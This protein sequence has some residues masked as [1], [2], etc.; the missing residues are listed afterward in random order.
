VRAGLFFLTLCISQLSF[1][2]KRD[3]VLREVTVYGL[4]EEKY[5]AGSILQPLDSSLKAN[6]RSNNLGEILSYQLPVYFRTYGNGMS[7]GISM[8]GTSPQHTSVLWNGINVNSFS[9]G[10]ADF[11]ILPA[12]AFDEVKVH[13][14]AGSA[15]YGSGA[16]GGSILMNSFSSSKKNAI[17]IAQDAG[18]FGRY[19]SSISG[20]YSTGRW[21]FKTNLYS[22]SS[23]NN[24]LILGTGEHQQHASF[25]QSGALQDIEYKFT[26]GKSL[27][28]HYWY[29]NADRQIQPAIG[30]YNSSDTQQDRNH[31]LSIHYQSHSQ[32]GLLSL[33]GGYIDDVIVFNGSGSDVTR[34]ISKAKHEFVFAQTFHAQVSA[35]W[36]HIIGHIPNYQDGRAQEDRY[37]FTSS[38][39]K[40]IGQR[41]SF[42]INLRQPVVPGFAAPFLPYIGIEFLPMKK[43]GNELKVY[44]SVS[45]NYRV[46]TLNDRYW[47]NAGDRN[48]LPETSHA[49]EAGWSWRYKKLEIFNAW[50]AQRVDDWIQWTPDATGNYRPKNIEQVLARGIELKINARPKIKNIVIV[51]MLSYQLTQSI[52]TKAPANQQYTIGNQLIFTPRHTASAFVQVLWNSYSFDVSAQYNGMRFTDAGNTP[53]YA[54]PAYALLNF[55]AGRNWVVHQHRFDVRFAVKNILNTDYQLY[56]AHAMPGR[57]YNLQINYQFNFKTN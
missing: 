50:F 41:L 10:Q 23:E 44:G 32:F 39:Q 33:N 38:L 21:R 46:P 26:E 40:N 11:S 37:D 27:G 2:Q 3:S 16:F 31:R 4:P 29:H 36:N 15:R 14:G 45:K 57:N 43:N 19:F 47:Q 20:S 51:P 30:Q 12:A 42:A 25:R 52:T 24:F 35:E 28:I 6:N 8:R 13:E 55:S 54:L 48:L 9:L 34:W 5:L 18:S 53:I 49:A 7:S 22:L 1:A 17:S 56:S